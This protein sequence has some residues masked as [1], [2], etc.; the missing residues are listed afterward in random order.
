MK[1]SAKDESNYVLRAKTRRT[2]HYESVHH[3]GSEYKLDN[4]SDYHLLG[5]LS[6]RIPTLTHSISIGIGLRPQRNQYCFSAPGIYSSIFD[7]A[8]ASGFY[9]IN[10]DN[11]FSVR[12]I[13]SLH[14]LTISYLSFVYR[15]N[16]KM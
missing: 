9:R 6:F 8:F 3:P 4:H 15:F 1:K 14:L 10:V 5:V 7:I 13:F 11:S 2:N 16:S 12:S